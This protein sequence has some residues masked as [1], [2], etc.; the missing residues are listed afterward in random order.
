M[1]NLQNFLET[2]TTNDAI[3]IGFWQLNEL[4]KAMEFAK[5]NNMKE[6]NVS[7]L[8]LESKSVNFIKESKYVKINQSFK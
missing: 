4:E 3:F 1:E 2:H 5:N 7:K 8:V 6:E